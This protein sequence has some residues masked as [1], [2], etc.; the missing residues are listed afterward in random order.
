MFGTLILE[1]AQGNVWNIIIMQQ[2]SN[3]ILSLS[4]CAPLLWFRAALPYL[5]MQ[6]QE[7]ILNWPPSLQPANV[8]NFS[9]IISHDIFVFI[10]CM[11]ILQETEPLPEFHD[12][13]SDCNKLGP[14]SSS[15]AT[16]GGLAWSV[17]KSTCN[18]PSVYTG[19]VCKEDLLQWKKCIFGSNSSSSIIISLPEYQYYSEE[20]ALEILNTLSQFSAKHN[21]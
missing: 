12:N 10:F 11:G 15:P 16:C 5:T 14:S 9:I 3:R 17:Q 2:T 19:S 21:I 20:E 18:S 13:A 6:V 1:K 4:F 7:D 8:V